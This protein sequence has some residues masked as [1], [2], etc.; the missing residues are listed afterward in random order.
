MALQRYSQCL[1]Q[2]GGLF[3]ER[4]LLELGNAAGK[5]KDQ[6]GEPPIATA[7]ERWIFYI[8]AIAKY[9]KIHKGYG[10]LRARSGSRR[11]DRVE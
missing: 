8:L 9:L 4:P 7:Q 2:P 1:T 11:L 6:I 5:G 10:D 3:D